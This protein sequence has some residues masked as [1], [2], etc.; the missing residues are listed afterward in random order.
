[1]TFAGR[2][3][4]IADIRYNGECLYCDPAAD[5]EMAMEHYKK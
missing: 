4:A 1:M 5:H 2:P 3:H